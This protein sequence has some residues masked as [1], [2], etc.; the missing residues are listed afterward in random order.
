MPR[1]VNA[2]A[3]RHDLVREA[4][5]LFDR[6]GYH[7]VNV[8]RLARA[9]GISQSTLYHYFSSKSEILCSIH[10]E[11]IDL[12]L[13]QQAA[14]AGTPPLDELRAVMTDV[15]ALMET[16]RGH[17]RVFFEHHRELDEADR[18]QLREKRDA[19]FTGVRRAIV[20]GIERGELRDDDPSLLALALFGMCNWAYQWFDADGPRSSEQVAALFFDLLANG[21]R[22]R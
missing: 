21:L 7:S 9:V 19:Y 11:F 16:H 12:L 14:R 17:V 8:G 15:L 10:E 20:D 13:E 2:D 22:A 1:A 18:S 6:D 3:R 4:A 5:E